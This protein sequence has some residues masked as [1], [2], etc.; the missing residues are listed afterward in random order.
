MLK[1]TASWDLDETSRPSKICVYILG[2]SNVQLDN[3]IIGRKESQTLLNQIPQ[4]WNRCCLRVRS[5]LLSV[6]DDE[7]EILID[8]DSKPT[9]TWKGLQ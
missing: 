4:L 9:V 5:Y 1:E 8:G 2:S 7:A 6:E 3:S